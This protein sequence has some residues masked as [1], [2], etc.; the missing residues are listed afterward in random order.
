M[1]NITDKASVVLAERPPTPV[2]VFAPICI[3][4]RVFSLLRVHDQ[5][6]KFLILFYNLFFKNSTQKSPALYPIYNSAYPDPYSEYGF[7]STKLLTT[8]PIQMRIHNTG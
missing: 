8:D 1:L 4:I 6:E 7:A 2:T 3:Q 5:F